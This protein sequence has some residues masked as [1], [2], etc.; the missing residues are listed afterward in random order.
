MN[1]FEIEWWQRVREDSINAIQSPE[2]ESDQVEE[3]S[4]DDGSN[5][6]ND[7]LEQESIG[8][9]EIITMLDKIK[10]YPAFDDDS[11]YILSSISKWIEDLQLKSRKQSSLN[12]FMTEAVII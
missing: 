9:K 11:Q 6:Q 10:P 12:P 3:I 4:D 2:I 1:E 5:D 7:E 8:L